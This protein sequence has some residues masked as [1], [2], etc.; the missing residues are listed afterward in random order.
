[1]PVSVSPIDRQ[2]GAVSFQLFFQRGNQFSG[3]LVDRAL[4][5]K[6]VIVFGYSEKPLTRDIFSAQHVF[7]KGN[8]FFTRFGSAE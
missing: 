6:V 1:M 5:F 3:L 2:R 7:Q 8:H 4:A